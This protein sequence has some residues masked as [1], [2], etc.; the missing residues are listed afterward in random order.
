MRNKFDEFVPK[1]VIKVID[2]TAKFCRA[3]RDSRDFKAVVMPNEATESSRDLGKTESGQHPKVGASTS[4]ASIRKMGC[5][6]KGPK[7]DEGA[8]NAPRITLKTLQYAP[9]LSQRNC[10]T[11]PQLLEETRSSPRFLSHAKWLELNTK[12]LLKS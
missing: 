8:P 6:G 2:K 9:R 3:Q 7:V 10:S 12:V 1:I 4:A 11:D 5:A